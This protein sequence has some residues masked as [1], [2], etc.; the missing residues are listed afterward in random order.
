ML[1]GFAIDSLIDA[2]HGAAGNKA[3]CAASRGGGLTEQWVKAIAQSKVTKSSTDRT[4]ETPG[5][6]A[7]RMP[8]SS[9]WREMVRERFGSKPMWRSIAAMAA[10]NVAK[11]TSKIEKM[12]V[13]GQKE[14]PL[15]KL[16]RCNRGGLREG[17]PPSYYDPPERLRNR[18]QLSGSS[19]NLCV[20][21]RCKPHDAL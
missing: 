6:P 11:A 12:K 9:N 19:R 18:L 5:A 13:G 2:K 1:G 8:A 10:D 15:P 14:T 7:R 21:V 16:G 20:V 17:E 3:I 4:G